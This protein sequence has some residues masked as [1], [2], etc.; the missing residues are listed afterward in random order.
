[1][2]VCC[3]QLFFVFLAAVH[4][5]FFVIS[6]FFIKPQKS[7][8]VKKKQL[9]SCL[10][11]L[12]NL[13]YIFLKKLFSLHKLIYPIIP[14]SLL[15]GAKRYTYKKW[16]VYK[17]FDTLSKCARI[18]F[19]IFRKLLYDFLTTCLN[20]FICRLT[21]GIAC[22]IWKSSQK[23]G[24]DFHIKNWFFQKL[25]LLLFVSLP[26]IKLLSETLFPQSKKL[27]LEDKLIL[28]FTLH[29]CVF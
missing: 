18:K 14:L 26:T 20:T 13:Q 10:K 17:I 25:I 24:D 12:C 19:E 29:N 2:A 28:F 27:F 3:I 7:I 8:Y 6:I 11:N 16:I 1:M 21:R 4:C 23:I 5:L 15:F 9:H 22:F